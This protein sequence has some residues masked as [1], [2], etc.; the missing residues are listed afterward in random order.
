MI[1]KDGVGKDREGKK[2]KLRAKANATKDTKN[3]IHNHGPEFIRV[4]N[5]HSVLQP[6][7][8]LFRLE[9]PSKWAGWLPI[10]EIEVTDA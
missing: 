9:D 8:S 2:V 1:L 7:K 10:R 6:G 4:E 3:A 5:F